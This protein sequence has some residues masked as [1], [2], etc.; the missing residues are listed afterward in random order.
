[1]PNRPIIIQAHDNLTKG[2][3]EYAPYPEEMEE[4]IR[5]IKNNKKDGRIHTQRLKQS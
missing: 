4:E 3:R 5:K 2:R 1:M